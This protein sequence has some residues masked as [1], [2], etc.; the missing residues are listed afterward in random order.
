MFSKIL[1]PVDLNKPKMLESLCQAAAE[2]AK[3]NN[4]DIT[5]MTVLPGYSMPMVASYFPEDAQKRLKVETRE[6]LDKLAKQ[7]FSDSKVSVKSGKRA[8]E[9]VKTANEGAYDLVIIGA[10]RKH[11]RG[12]ERLLGSCSQSVSDRSACSV[13]IVR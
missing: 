5:L 6:A 1:V 4:A 9:I 11:S 12:S 13:M 7:Y 3:A 8:K 10:R 2:L